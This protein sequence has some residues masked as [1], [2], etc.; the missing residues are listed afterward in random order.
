MQV[1]LRRDYKFREARALKI[2]FF[3][4][5][6]YFEAHGKRAIICF[7]NFII[8]R[9]GSPEVAD[10]ATVDNQLG[11]RI[12]CIVPVALHARWQRLITTKSFHPSLL[13][14]WLDAIVGITEN[15]ATHRFL[16]IFFRKRPERTLTDIARR[17]PCD[18]RERSS[19]V[20]IANVVDRHLQIH[21]V[22]AFRMVEQPANIMR[23]IF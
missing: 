19:K 12:F 23:A 7:Y 13:D 3:G 21:S 1:A 5:V 10:L 20:G 4:L 11:L 9:N 14:N 15:A 2:V 6:I 16:I 17:I 8:I 18:A 22:R